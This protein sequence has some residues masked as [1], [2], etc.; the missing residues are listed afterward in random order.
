[1]RFKENDTKVM[2]GSALLL[3]TIAISVDLWFVDQLASQRVVGVLMATE[4]VAFAMVCYLYY[5]QTFSELSGLW[6]LIG[7]GAMAIFLMLALYVGQ[8]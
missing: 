5:R 6:L 7:C 3:V 2:L 8:G 1:L 4:L